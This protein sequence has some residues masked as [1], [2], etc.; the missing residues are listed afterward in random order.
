[1]PSLFLGA[2]ALQ[3]ASL[4]CNLNKT[5]ATKNHTGSVL[6]STPF[7]VLSH[8]L[9]V[10][11]PPRAP[12]TSP[13]LSFWLQ[14]GWQ[15]PQNLSVHLLQQEEGSSLCT[16]C[17]DLAS[18]ALCC[19]VQ[20]VG[21]HIHL[22]T[23]WQVRC[24]VLHSQCLTQKLPWCGHLIKMWFSEWMDVGSKSDWMNKCQTHWWMNEHESFSAPSMLKEMKLENKTKLGMLGE[25][26]LNYI[27]STPVLYA[28]INMPGI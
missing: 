17:P 5:K 13:H 2:W 20:F 16:Q 15:L 27:W 4:T 6:P 24:C 3:A 9:L 1:M 28:M 12:L 10:Q 25:S 23:K 11:G 21:R 26:S 14:L 7:S 8:V 19:S 18:Q 22:S